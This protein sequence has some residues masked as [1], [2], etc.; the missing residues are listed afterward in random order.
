MQLATSLEG[1]IGYGQT[2]AVCDDQLAEQVEAIVAAKALS[3]TGALG[4]SAGACCGFWMETPDGTIWCT[5]DSRLI[6]QQFQMR[7]MDAILLD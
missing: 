7:Q 6:P 3:R 5:E 4:R 2:N 1:K